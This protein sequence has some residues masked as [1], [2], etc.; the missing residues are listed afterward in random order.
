MWFPSL[1]HFLS[2]CLVILIIKKPKKKRRKTPCFPLLLLLLPRA[3]MA[4]LDRSSGKSRRRGRRR[5]G[6]L[7]LLLGTLLRDRRSSPRGARRRRHARRRS[8]HRRGS[9]AR[10][11]RRRPWPRRGVD[12][13]LDLRH[14]LQAPRCGLQRAQ[15][16]SVERRERRRQALT[17]PRVRGDLGQRHARG[18]VGREQP[19]QEVR[20][21]GGDV[22]GALVLGG[23]DAGEHLL[24]ADEV[25]G[26]LVASLGEGQGAFEA[27]F[28][29]GGGGGGSEF[30]FRGGEVS[31]SGF[32]VI[33]KEVDMFGKKKKRSSYPSASRRASPRKTRCPPSSRRTRR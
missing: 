21:R 11:A 12:D 24:Q 6:G 20:R 7:L 25:V 8:R 4:R 32:F 19:A 10:G 33:P 31:F 30:L 13:P 15:Q 27:V 17:E 2:L 18:G 9:R 1:F 29:L 23:D 28:F 16:R 22:R 26:A 3:R 5:R 14:R